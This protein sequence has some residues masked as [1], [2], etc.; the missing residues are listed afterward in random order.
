MRKRAAI[1]AAFF[2]LLTF[3]AFAQDQTEHITN[4]DSDITVARN[5]VL[6]VTET[7][8]VIAQGEQIHH[9]IYR[10][11]P[12]T[13][14]DKLG[15]EIHV[16]FDVEQVTRD[17]QPEHYEVDDIDAGKRVKIGDA[18]TEVPI[19]PH[20][21]TITYTT[22]RQI[23]FFKDYDELYWNVT[24]NFWIFPIDHAQATV[25]LPAGAHIIQESSY[26]GA[27]GSTANNARAQTVFDDTIRFETTAPLGAQ[28]GLTIA[29]GFSKGAVLPPT[30][31]EKRADFI[32]DN[33][34]SLIAVLG[35]LILLIYFGVTWFEFGRDPPHGTIIAVFAPPKDFSPAAVRFVYRMAYDRK[36][37]AATLVD[38]AVKGFMKISE[39]DETYTLTRTGKSEMDAGLSSGERAIAEKLFNIDAAGGS[40]ELKQD[41]HSAIAE[42]ISALKTSLKNEYEKN[43]FATNLH[44]FIGGAAI[45]AL[46]AVASALLGP[47]AGASGFML[48]WMSDWSIGTAFLL[49]RAYDACVTVFVGPGS[50]FLNFF[51]ALFASAFA[52]PFLGGLI[53]VLVVFGRTISLPSSAALIAGGVACYVFYHLLKAPTLMGA[54]ILDLI[55]GFR[56]YLNTAE[57]DRLEV[58]NPPKVTPDVFEKFLPYAIALDCENSWS[59]KFESEAAAAGVTPDQSGAYYS[60][61]WYSG[62]SFGRLGSAGF[63]SA[64]GA[65]MASAAANASS[66]PGSS[67]GSGRRWILRRRR[68]VVS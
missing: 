50:R 47:N 22:D 44:W 64:L 12:T 2:A 41:N 27:T 38:M 66:A 54:K 18:D 56:L 30:D 34:G 11:F 68:R 33:A 8:A 36:A 17:G 37:F 43:Y 32:R 15:R 7:I 51:G 62:S 14:S 4:Y 25:R 67:S 57:K 45:L 39:E 53:F 46:T 24:G 52:L 40:I 29:A 58:L 3:P 9:G 10:D 35:V 65:S 60:P 5:G 63:V 42:A 49:H 61:L 21:Y 20:T 55:Q 6:T 13:Y 1:V 23:G 28:E 31:A 19:G 26:T 59:K 48:V 16:R